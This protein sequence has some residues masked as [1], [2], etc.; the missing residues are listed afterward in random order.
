M[1][2]QNQKNQNLLNGLIHLHIPLILHGMVMEHC[3]C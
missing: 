2:D 3:I 1:K